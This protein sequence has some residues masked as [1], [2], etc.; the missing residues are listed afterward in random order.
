MT[1]NK[2]NV[3]TFSISSREILDDGQISF[4]LLHKAL[5]H[6][7]VHT[8]FSSFFFVSEM[9]R[10][11]FVNFKPQ[12]ISE[13]DLKWYSNEADRNICILIQQC[14]MPLGNDTWIE[15]MLE[16]WNEARSELAD[17]SPGYSVFDGAPMLFLW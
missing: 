13:N 5:K 8:E 15:E 4:A 12:S 17:S 7:T 6:T 16:Y 10:C 11:H 14:V 9:F 3:D 1:I 2:E